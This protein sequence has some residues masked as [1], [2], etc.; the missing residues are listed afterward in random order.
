MGNLAGSQKS[1][2]DR[3]G[4][5][6]GHFWL[7][8]PKH[9]PRCCVWRRLGGVSPRCCRLLRRYRGRRCRTKTGGLSGAEAQ[10]ASVISVPAKARRACTR[11]SEIKYPDQLDWTRPAT[12]KCLL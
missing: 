12:K 5:R 4:D 11:L 1:N 8:R 3:G 7:Q 6:S 2:E 10:A 9:I